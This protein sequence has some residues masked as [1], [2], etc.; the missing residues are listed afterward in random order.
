MKIKDLQSIFQLK[1]ES[2]ELAQML[3]LIARHP[4]LFKT[5]LSKQELEISIQKELANKM[6]K[7]TSF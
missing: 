1:K 4:Y 6:Q 3:N 7:M 2:D 5:E